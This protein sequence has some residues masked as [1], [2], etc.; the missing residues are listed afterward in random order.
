MCKA[1]FHRTIPSEKAIK[2][3][4]L[5]ALPSVRSSA[6]KMTSQRVRQFRCKLLS[7]RILRRHLA[8]NLYRYCFNDE[9]NGTLY[10]YVIMSFGVA[11]QK[12]A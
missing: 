3:V 5:H 8:G 2:C 1:S 9:Y 6:N 10:N 12:T 7:K 4:K 11:E